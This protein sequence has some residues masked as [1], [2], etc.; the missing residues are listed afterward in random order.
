MA[1][2]M[3][4]MVIPLSSGCLAMWSSMHCCRSRIQLF[5]SCAAGGQEL[6]SARR[7]SNAG[8]LEGALLGEDDPGLLRT[9]QIEQI[10]IRLGQIFILTCTHVRR[11]Y[12]LI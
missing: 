7:H 5:F 3:V 10:L 1:M 9:H 12:M 4:M 8:Y 6:M 2:V 11:R